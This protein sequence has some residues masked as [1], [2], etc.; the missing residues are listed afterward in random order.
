LL[1][2]VLNTTENLPYLNTPISTSW[3]VYR[4]ASFAPLRYVD[5]TFFSPDLTLLLTL[6]TRTGV[7]LYSGCHPPHSQWKH[8]P[9]W[10]HQVYYLRYLII[11]L[12]WQ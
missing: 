10:N 5:L 2:E 8:L 11:P 12:S 7:L 4:M 9:H 3:S 1:L 6:L